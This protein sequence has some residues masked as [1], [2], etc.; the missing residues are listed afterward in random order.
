M[1]ELFKISLIAYVFCAL[2]SPGMIF[3]WYQ[4]I[5]DRLPY[6][7]AN[8]LGACHKCLTG[9]VCFW[10]FLVKYFNEYNLIDHL[11]FTSSGIFLSLIYNWLWEHLES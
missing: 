5:L 4:R 6:W 3:A 2:G 10:F 9:Q 11:A 7:L 8:P 1:I